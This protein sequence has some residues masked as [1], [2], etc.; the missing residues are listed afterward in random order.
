MKSPSPPHPR[1]RCLQS[2]T[3]SELAG[4]AGR[5]GDMI[6]GCA[7]LGL[8]GRCRS[9]V[10][11]PVRRSHRVTAGPWRVDCGGA[12]DARFGAPPQWRRGHR[13]RVR[14]CILVHEMH[15]SKSEEDE[16]MF[17]SA[18]R[19]TRGE[20]A[21]WPG[22]GRGGAGRSFLVVVVA[23]TATTV[24]LSRNSGR[25]GRHGGAAHRDVVY[26]PD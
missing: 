16:L 15:L 18:L 24:G 12:I 23:Q 8:P 20:V 6:H 5:R 11:A 25:G 19:S 4:R 2:R 13:W 7:A 17:E 3:E 22:G 14:G 26:W 10:E 21:P 9:V 1:Q